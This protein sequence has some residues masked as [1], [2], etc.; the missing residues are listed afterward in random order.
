ME[1]KNLSQDEVFE[2][3]EKCQKAIR[4]VIKAIFM[5]LVVSVLMVWIVICNPSQIWAWGVSALV[6]LINLVGCMPLVQEYRKQKQLLRML[7]EME[8]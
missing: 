1:E 6:L 5:R 4:T 8:E 7:I 3:E 2:Q